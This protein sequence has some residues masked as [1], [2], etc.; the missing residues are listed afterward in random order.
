M[1]SC[2]VTVKLRWSGGCRT[3]NPLRY[4]DLKTRTDVHGELRPNY[5]ILAFAIAYPFLRSSDIGEIWANM[6]HNVYAA[7][8][9]KLGFAAYAHTNAL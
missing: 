6:L 7:L 8:V 4:S 3:T 9:D 2:L 5:A 1:F